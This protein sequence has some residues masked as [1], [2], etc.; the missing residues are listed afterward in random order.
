[1]QRSPTPPEEQHVWHDS[2][3]HA[4]ERLGK[5]AKDIQV[6]QRQAAGLVI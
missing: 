5:S 1:M 2:H 3:L 6:V 4:G